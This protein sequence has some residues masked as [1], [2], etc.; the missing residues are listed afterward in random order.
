MTA[1]TTALVTAVDLC[2][3]VLVITNA[4]YRKENLLVDGQLFL[5]SFTSRTVNTPPAHVTIK[6]IQT[7]K[8]KLQNMSSHFQEVLKT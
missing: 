4:T 2:S 1:G 7:V 3:V 5:P 6:K 8:K